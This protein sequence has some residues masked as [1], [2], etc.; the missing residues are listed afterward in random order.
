MPLITRPPT[1]LNKF[2]PSKVKLPLGILVHLT[3]FDSSPQGVRVREARRNA[4]ELCPFASSRENFDF[5]SGGSIFTN[6]S[7]ARS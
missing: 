3:S 5:H 1:L 6:P 7:G 2:R 4:F